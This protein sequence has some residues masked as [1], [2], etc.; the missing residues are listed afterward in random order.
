[1]PPKR[2]AASDDI[3]H[4]KGLRSHSRRPV[5]PQLPSWSAWP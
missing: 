3:D 5:L 4:A 1:M 2:G